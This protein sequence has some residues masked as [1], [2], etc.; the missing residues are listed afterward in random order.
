[1]QNRPIIAHPFVK[2]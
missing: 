1:M 2:Q